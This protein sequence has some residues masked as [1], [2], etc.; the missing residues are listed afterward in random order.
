MPILLSHVRLKT[1]KI[2]GN[3]LHVCVK[4]TVS[5]NLETYRRDWHRVGGIVLCVSTILTGKLIIGHNFK[6][7]LLRS[8]PEKLLAKMKYGL[9]LTIFHTKV[10][11][12]NVNN[13]GTKISLVF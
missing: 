2:T 7:I 11:A 10:T 3:L 9:R 8:S 1:H 4:R 5:D 13:F 12:L 6:H